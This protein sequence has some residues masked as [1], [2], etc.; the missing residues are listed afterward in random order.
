MT[1]STMQSLYSQIQDF[2]QELSDKSWVTGAVTAPTDTS[3]AAD[4]FEGYDNRPLVVGL[5]GGTGA[6]KSSLLNRLAGSDVARTGVVRPTSMEITAYLHKDKKIT[7]LPEGFPQ[8]HFAQVSHS[9]DKFKEVMWVDMPD[10]DS[11]ET[12]NRDQVVQWLPYIDVVIYVVTPERYR[13]AEGWRLLQSHGYRHGWLFVM[14]QWDKA[15]DIQLDDFREL[16]IATGFAQPK[17]FTTSCVVDDL[18]GDQLDS[19]T[20]LVANLSQ[21]NVVAQLEQYGWLQRLDQA[22]QRLQAQLATLAEPEEELLA[23]FDQHWKRFETEVVANSVLPM[24][25][26]SERFAQGTRSPMRHVL[27]SVTGSS[28]SNGENINIQALVREASGLWNDWSAARL[29]DT[30]SQFELSASAHGVPVSRFKSG[31][32]LEK[33]VAGIG[34]SWQQQVSQAVANP[35]QPWQR[36]LHKTVGWLRWLLPVAVG[37]WIAIRVVSGFVDGAQDRAAYVGFDFLVNGLMLMAMVWLIPQIATHFL[38]PSVPKAVQRSLSQALAQDL[39][40]FAERYRTGLSSVVEE[41]QALRSKAQGLIKETED[42]QAR[43]KLLENPEL[44][45]LLLTR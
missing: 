25:E 4:L 44:D 2:Q 27:Q 32:G 9:S 42:M 6:G 23:S 36:Q 37:I 39:H 13:D 12:Q 28:D 24:R 16:L 14:N 22:E 40:G 7:A 34:D 29:K 10:F 41:R 26:Y 38:K 21:R 45:G 18:A 3:G 35:G 43:F 11:E 30:L 31:R 8:N 1:D 17:I 33:S 15:E 5:F 19:L 20:T